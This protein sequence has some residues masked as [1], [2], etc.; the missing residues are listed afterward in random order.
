[1]SGD[2]SGGRERRTSAKTLVSEV[3]GRFENSAC[4]LNQLMAN[5]RMTK[6]KKGEMM[7]C[8]NRLTSCFNDIMNELNV[9]VAINET[10]QENSSK[11]MELIKS[12]IAEEVKK[13]TSTQASTPSFSDIVSTQK[14]QKRIAKINLPGVKPIPTSNSFS[15]LIYPGGEEIETSDQTKDL[16]TE[17]VDPS[18]LGLQIKRI[19]RVANKGICLESDS[20]HLENKLRD[21]EIFKK[22]QL[23]IKKQE[24][25]NPRIAVYSVKNTITE[26]ELERS[27][28]NQNRLNDSAIV[29][30]LFRFGKRNDYV[31]NWV[32]ELDPETR[33]LVIP[34][35]KIYI[36]FT[37]CKISD[38][39]HITRCYKCQGF[40]HL[41]KDCKNEKDCC[42][43]CAGEHKYKDCEKKEEEICCSN[44]KKAN[45]QD[46]KHSVSDQNCPIFCR[47]RD[48]IV[49]SINYG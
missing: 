22:G 39:I 29:K 46:S 31:T 32:V 2:T 12:T 48:A 24:K 42:S 23:V 10:V 7:T 33:N 14:A 27:I 17:K 30:P 36:D 38:H 49:N 35:G 19:R 8:L 45:Q 1:M 11:T 15:V 18:K 16:L 47:L 43:H 5:E 21:C 3:K 26:Q 4:E 9:Q 25:R 6:E 44:C 34:H 20:D 40:G 13:I 41:A 37:S 28:R